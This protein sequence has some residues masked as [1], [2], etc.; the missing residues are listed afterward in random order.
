MPTIVLMDFNSTY[1][2][3]SSCF[4]M[5]LQN[6]LKTMNNALIVAILVENYFIT[7]KIFS[8][9]VITIK[10]HDLLVDL[11]L[12]EFRDFDAILGMD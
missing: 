12:L 9:C 1:S 6:N 8:N 5:R 7:D 3:I 4:A 10:I 11:I 2:F